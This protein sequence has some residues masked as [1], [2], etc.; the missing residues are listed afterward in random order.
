MSYFYTSRNGQQ[1]GPLS[2]ETI[3]E[4]ISRS[5]FAASD[6]IYDEAT[7]EWVSFGVFQHTAEMF[8]DGKVNSEEPMSE[9]K[10]GQIEN[11][12]GGSETAWYVLKG[13][14]KFGP[15]LYLDLVGMLQKKAIEEYDYVWNERMSNW[16][17]IADSEDFSHEKLKALVMATEN[18]ENQIFFRRRFARAP[19]ASSLVIHNN[20]RIWKGQSFQISAGGAGLTIDN[21]N[22]VK[23][24]EVYLHFK[25]G[26]KVPPFN[27]QCEIV[28]LHDVKDDKGITRQ[29]IGVRFLKVNYLIQKVINDFVSVEKRSNVA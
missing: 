19:Y 21:S 5:Y 20:L 4:K 11:G 1:E 28:A 25:P 18:E 2:I 8:F 14:E 10:S 16:I 15:F 6:F 9:N 7:H 23:G 27:S 22:L 26:L 3:K 17:R 29:H 13:E 12:E 24:D